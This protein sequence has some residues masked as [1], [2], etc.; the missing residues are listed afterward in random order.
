MMEE[1]SKEAKMLCV[2]LVK[3]RAHLGTECTADKVEPEAAR[4]PPAMGNV[5]NVTS[6]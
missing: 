1:D 2:K 5:L 6:K 3:E 4:C